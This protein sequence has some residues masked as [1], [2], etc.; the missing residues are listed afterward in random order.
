[1]HKRQSFV[2]IRKVR[3]PWKCNVFYFLKA[4]SRLSYLQSDQNGDKY[5]KLSVRSK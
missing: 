5:N 3:I 1:M 4:D 2:V